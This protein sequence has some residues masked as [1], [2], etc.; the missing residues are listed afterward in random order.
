MFPWTSTL[1]GYD[2]THS[3][4]PH[5]GLGWTEQHVTADVALAFR[6]YFFQTG[7][8]EFLRRSWSLINGTCAFWAGR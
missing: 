6:H 5:T 3:T 4:T 1:S 2:D 7:D 8:K